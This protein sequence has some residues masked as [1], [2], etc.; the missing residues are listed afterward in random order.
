MDIKKHK[1][2]RRAVKIFWRIVVATSCILFAAALAL[3]LPQV[4]T[5]IADKVIT[6]LS[7]KLD[8]DISFEKIHFKPFTTLVLKNVIITDRSPVHDTV[9]STSVRIDTFFR[10]EYIIASFTLDGLVR[11]EGIH[12]DKAYVDNAQMNLVI[13]NKPDA[14]DGDINTDNLSRIFRIKESDGSDESEKEIFNIRKV[15]IRNMGFLMK[16]YEF[17]RPIYDK[18]GIDWNDLD[19]K[20]INLHAKGLR[21]KGGIMSGEVISLNFREK[22]GYR[23]EQM[24]GD[25]RV[26]KG[27]TIIEDL[28]IDDPWSDVSLPLYMMSYD[29]I[30]A[31]NDFIS[32]VKIDG[33][34]AE[35]LL[36][37]RTL[38]YF[39]PELKGCNLSAVVSGG[40]SGYVDDF[41]FSDVRINSTAG[42]FKGKA[43]GRLVGLPD[44][45][46]THLDARLD[47]FRFTA[48]GLG[49]FITEWMM[50]K[51]KLD[52]SRFAQGT[53]FSLDAHGSG[54]MNSLGIDAD[55]ASAIGKAKADVLISNMVSPGRQIGISG[56]LKTEDLDLGRIIGSDILG[57]ATL[58]TVLNARIGTE[59]QP[60][61]AKIDTLRIDHIYANGYDYSD[62]TATGNISSNGFDGS[63]ACHDPNLNFLF[64]GGF[65]LS[66][67]TQ[68][69]RYSF[70]TNIGHADLNAIN[71]DKRG[72]S[73]VHLRASADFTKTSTGDISGKIDVGDIVLQNSLGTYRIG[74]ANLS[75]YSS[76]S[77]YIMRLESKFLNGSYSGSAPVAEFVKDL[78]NVTLKKELPAMFA[79]SSYTWKGNT[80]S[81]GFRFNNSMDLLSFVMPGLYIDEGTELKAD[82]DRNGRMS[83]VLNSNRLAFKKNY[84]KGLEADFSNSDDALNGLV[85]CSEIKFASMSLKDS[86]LNLHG[87]D[88]HL[89]IKFD[90]DNDS[91]HANMGE[92]ILHSAF[93]RNGSGL[94]IGV[95][96]L[97][98][99]LF[100]NSKEWN[101][102]PSEISLSKDGIDVGSFA[103]A[104]GEER[105]SIAGRASK[106]EPDTLSLNLDRFDMSIA[107]D[108][109]KRDLGIKGA[110]TGSIQLT[111][112]LKD[113]GI[114]ADLICDSTYFAGTP[115]GILNIG[116]RWNDDDNSFDIVVRN[117][118]EGRSSINAYGTFA[119]DINLL[120]ASAD[121]DRFSIS[122]AQPLLAD[123]FSRMDGSISGQID[124]SGPLSELN[125][126][127]RGARLDDGL[128]KVAYTNVPYHASGPFHL[129]ETGA[130]FD[131]IALR[132]DHTGKGTVTGSINWDRFRDIRFNTS[133]TIDE[134][135]GI[136]ISEDNADGFYGRAF[137]TGQVNI[138]GPMNDILLTVDAV[139]SKAG[140]LHIPVSGEAATGKVTNL[141]QFTE[142]ESSERVDP[143]EAM[144]VKMDER[145][146][147]QSDF[148]VK[149]RINA[150]PEVE[151]FIEIDKASGNVLSG[152]GSGIIDLESGTDVF[153]INGDYIL[154][155]G[156]YKFVAMN[157]VG[158]DFQIEDGS[159][160]RFNG[161]IMNS[162]LDINAIYRTKASLSTLLSD[163]SSVSNK[164]NV[165]CGISITGKLSNPELGFSIEIPDLNPMIKSR[166]ES[167]L[168]SDDKVQKQFLSLILSNSFLPDEQSG[169]VNNTTLLYSNVTEALAN[170][171]NN[172]FHKLDIP[173][174]LGLNYQPNESGNDLFDVAVS[175]QLFNNRVVVNGNIGNKQYTTSG[176]QNDVV[177]DLDIEIKLNRSGAFRLNLFSHSADQFSNYLDNSQ[178]NGV[179]LMY[180]TEFNSFGKFI[181]NIF[182][183]K[184]K[185][186]AAK[187]EEEQAMIQGRKV[188]IR[189][190]APEKKQ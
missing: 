8:G 100:I 151:A 61:E 59:K 38:S 190:E 54:M 97:P 71:L 78:K 185:R 69:A 39:A 91:E 109:L 37:F 156:S 16:N 102:L 45:E 166:V 133:I 153:N 134:M 177:G 157:I 147:D 146:K 122:Y 41:A 172:I 162:T 11:S 116:S 118:L 23:T 9:D 46:A 94:G 142:K 126:S 2:I 104:S 174:D 181:R 132:D 12:L 68:N 107:N 81:L 21:F 74:N 111:S 49:A 150:Q 72:L 33:N 70:Y 180:Q 25:V 76:D 64:Q 66:S 131:G 127:S 136:N 137:G 3:Q 18:G 175:T 77:T 27:R 30:L 42:G 58:K 82:I 73:R 50:G 178:R 120:D 179:G 139:T 1:V 169:I 186:Q 15:E 165:D 160:I 115:L 4:Q 52:L 189:I 87:K 129:D 188:N 13:E 22:S 29:N 184:A 99:S 117:E 170:Q 47:G 10:A 125:V 96:F 158:R 19:I 128:L 98:S 86:H 85:K 159:S 171:L 138:T 80:Y 187:M 119:P 110:A 155:S 152:R 143:Y 168:S 101:F 55:I 92:I 124:I 93:S 103:I 114:L 24:S 28:H 36:D 95:E 20:D 83:A 31:F 43:S 65:A 123:V 112:P 130:Y 161:D 63:I 53:E 84:L 105:I 167:A 164:R 57:P 6:G 62:I 173:L 40:M 182:M 79:D 88:D 183:R 32:L 113:K 5:Y 17:D 148:T 135:E 67:K 106:D 149:L 51:G 7:K 144:M 163:E 90:Y 89:G 14:G 48:E 75:S 145:E 176:T 121:L 35:S 108:I 26:G 44:I 56:S 141:L 140:Q 60:T 154:N 34:I